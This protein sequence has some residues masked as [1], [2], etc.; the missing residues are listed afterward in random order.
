MT[1]IVCPHCEAENRANAKFC[2]SCAKLMVNLDNGELLPSKKRRRRRIRT[3]ELSKSSGLLRPATLAI[4]AGIILLGGAW[5]YFTQDA[6]VTTAHQA[7]VGGSFRPH[8]A[9]LAKAAQDPKPVEPAP[10]TQLA[11]EPGS[12]PVV[13]PNYVTVSEPAANAQP[14]SKAEHAKTDTKP[15]AKP[16]AAK[17][18]K[19]EKAK[20]DALKVKQAKEAKE[21]R[22]AARRDK[23][24]N[25]AH[26]RVAE[27]PAPAPVA[28][29]PAPKPN[30][31]QQCQGQGFLSRAACMQSQCSQPGNAN[32]P[33]C[34]RM[35]ETQEALRRGS[36]GG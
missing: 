2:S 19:A 32:T 23:A 36:G 27:A 15:E 12:T 34:K 33:Q 28:P 6:R 10:I 5:W 21:A 7:E 8:P 29:A 9:D 24:R 20:A 14:D 26:E 35:Y 4:A 11:G 22:E 17:D 30:P 1:A 3:N 18:A 31:E 16:E 13:F 25:E